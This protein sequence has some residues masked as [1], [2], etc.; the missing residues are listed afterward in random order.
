MIENIIFD[1]DGVLVDSEILAGRAFVKYLKSHNM[2]FSEQ[3]F[4]THYAGNKTID[5]VSKLSLKYNINNKKFFFE[6]VMDIANNMFHNEL[7]TT[8]GIINF[9]KDIKQNK[10]IG[11]NSPKQRIV[12]GLKQTKLNKYFDIQKI[13]SFDEVEK[14]K[15]APDVYLKA[16]KVCNIKSNNTV[17]IE[18]SVVGTQ[19]GV[20]ANLKVIGLTS[21]GHWYKRS[22][23]S[24]I[25]AG[26]IAVASNC[27]DII[28]IIRNL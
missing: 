13:F 26:P 5:I 2:L 1:F 18:D 21:G 6:S 23:E 15:P 28:N 24:L 19:A 25:N 27:N 16:L 3:E 22:P 10:F 20:A 4:A 17:V 7:T 12:E 9:L 11:S 14:P 8:P